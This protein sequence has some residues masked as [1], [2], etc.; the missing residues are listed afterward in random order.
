VLIVEAVAELGGAGGQHH[1]V[2]A[3]AGEQGV[4]GGAQGGQVIGI[5]C[6]EVGHHGFTEAVC[7]MM[8]EPPS[9]CYP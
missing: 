7:R 6:G 3:V 9:V 4:V 1:G 5:E 8:S 2:E